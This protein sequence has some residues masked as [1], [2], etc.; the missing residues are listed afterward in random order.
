[1]PIVMIY[2]TY[3]AAEPRLLS[4]EREYSDEQFLAFAEELFAA[5]SKAATGNYEQRPVTVQ[6]LCRENDGWKSRFTAGL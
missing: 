4:L 2:P 5:I 3:N 6:I 1:M